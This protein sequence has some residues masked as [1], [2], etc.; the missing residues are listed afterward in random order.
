MVKV[1]TQPWSHRI[2]RYAVKAY[3]TTKDALGAIDDGVDETPVL[4]TDSESQYK[5]PIIEASPTTCSGLFGV[6]VPI[7]TFPFAKMVICGVASPFVLKLIVL[8]VLLYAIRPLYAEFGI[9]KSML[10][11]FVDAAPT[12]AIV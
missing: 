7:P 8:F 2:K 3:H 10:Q 11:L 6:V 9:E 4:F 12:K 5:L 1:K